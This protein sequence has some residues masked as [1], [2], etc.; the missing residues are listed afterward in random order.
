MKIGIIGFGERNFIPYVEVYENELKKANIQY[1]C[2]F[3]DRFKDSFVSKNS[4]E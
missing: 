4:N 2:I 3:W 1:E